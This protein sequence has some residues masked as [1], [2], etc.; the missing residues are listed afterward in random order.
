MN[1][2]AIHETIADRFLEAVVKLAA[3][4]RVGDPLDPPTALGPV[5]SLMHQQRVLEF[6]KVA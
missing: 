5:T 2:P 3:S 6:V 1:T 4:I